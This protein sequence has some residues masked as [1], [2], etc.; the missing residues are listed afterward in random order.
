MKTCVTCSMESE[1]DVVD[2]SPPT[3]LADYLDSRFHGTDRGDAGTTEG[4]RE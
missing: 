4:M 2:V 3:E 1:V